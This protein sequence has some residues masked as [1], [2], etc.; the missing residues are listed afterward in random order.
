MKCPGVWH[1]IL[2]WSGSRRREGEKVDRMLI[3]DGHQMLLKTLSLNISL[4]MGGPSLR[5]EVL[6]GASNP[7]YTI[8]SILPRPVLDHF[9]ILLDGGGLRQGLSPF[10][11]EKNGAKG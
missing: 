8:Q 6:M 9:P 5:A 11:F 3:L 7:G 1:V 2:I 10:K 4:H